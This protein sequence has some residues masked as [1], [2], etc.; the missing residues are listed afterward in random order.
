MASLKSSDI[1]ISTI[2]P[3]F[4]FKKVW[5]TPFIGRDI[6]KIAFPSKNIVPKKMYILSIMQ[7]MKDLLD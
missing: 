5:G 2:S 6:H 1:V 3:D 7:T 4:S